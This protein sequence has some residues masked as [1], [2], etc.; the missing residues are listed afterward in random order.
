MSLAINWVQFA[1]S[2]GWVWLTTGVWATGSSVSLSFTIGSLGPLGPLGCPFIFTNWAGPSG[3]AVR[4]LA[5][6]SACL[7]LSTTN[8]WPIII[9]RHQFTGSSMGPIV[10]CPS[11]TVNNYCPLHNC[12]SSINCS[13]VHW[14]NTHQLILHQY[15]LGLGSIW[16]LT[17][18]IGQLVIHYLRHSSFVRLLNWVITN[19]PV[20]S[21]IWS[22]GCHLRHWVIGSARSG[23]AFV[24]S[25]AVIAC[26]GLGCHWV[27][28]GSGSAGWLSGPGLSAV[29]VWATGLA[30][31]WVVRLGCPGW[32]GSVCLGLGCLGH[33]G[34]VHNHCL[35]FINTIGHCLSIIIPSS[36]GLPFL[37]FCLSIVISTSINLVSIWV[38][39]NI[40]SLAWSFTNNNNN[41]FRLGLG[42]CCHSS[43][44]VWVRSVI[45][46][47]VFVCQ[48]GLST[49][50]LACH[51]LSSISIGSFHPSILSGSSI[52]TN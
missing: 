6:P 18:V 52:T 25:S 20:S 15:Q 43:L 17:I 3:S 49:S 33:F 41:N 19:W 31:Y 34:W 50:S 21:V 38:F 28:A 35:S 30:Q 40:G 16:S 4:Q 22:F 11:S 44:P 27:W 24:W 36:I 8:N 10:N 12:L 46:V 39:N 7:G 51:W 45:F 32:P 29:W 42:H 5:C 23:S 47:F 26:L 9:V 48:L 13:I 37:V 1:R 2:L 14:V